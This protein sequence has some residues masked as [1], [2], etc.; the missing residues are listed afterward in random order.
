MGYS[1]ELLEQFPQDCERRLLIEIER[2]QGPTA[3]DNAERQV[4]LDNYARDI[5]SY[6]IRKHEQ[7]SDAGD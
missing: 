3:Y 6:E 4:Y 5:S 7:G 1:N 2:N